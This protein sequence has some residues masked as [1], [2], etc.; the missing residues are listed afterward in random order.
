MKLALL[1]SCGS[2]ADAQAGHLLS[3]TQGNLIFEVLGRNGVALSDCR[4]FSILPFELCAGCSDAEGMEKWFE[5]QWRKFEAET[6]AGCA[7]SGAGKSVDTATAPLTAGGNPA[8]LARLREELLAFAPAVILAL[9]AMPLRLLLHST[10]DTPRWPC[11]IGEWRGTPFES[12]WIPWEECHSDASVT[13]H[14]TK[15]IASY[16]P[17][18]LQRDGGLGAYS[19]VD[20][21]K[22][23][24]ELKAGPELVL[25]ERKVF[26]VDNMTDAMATLLNYTLAGHKGRLIALD[27]E[28][29]VGS[30]TMLGFSISPELAHVIPFVDGDG[31]SL[32]TEDEEVEIW[33]A[34]KVFLEDPTIA[35]V[36]QNWQSDSFILAWSYGI[37]T[38]GLAHDVMLMAWEAQPELEKGLEL[39]P[40]LLL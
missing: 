12:V 25:P 26:I 3:G 27:T 5:E 17:S 10:L 6:L 39:G 8:T 28:G 24:V 4:V 20:L 33:E 32:W 19:R 18:W 40:G 11:S 22:V 35:K 30:I 38:E 29:T 1:V 31:C 34:V 7:G 14:G 21:Q 15:C 23:A 2:K 37:V 36:W 9:G 13:A 16:H